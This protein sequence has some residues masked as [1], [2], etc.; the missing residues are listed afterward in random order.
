MAEFDLKHELAKLLEPFPPDAVEW[1]AQ[2][3]T[4][5]A[6]H[7]A[8]ALSYIDARC[9]MQRLDEV[10]GP[11]NWQCRYQFSPDGKKTI[12]EIGVKLD[13]EWVW[14]ADGAGDTDVEAE[15]GALSDSFKRAAVKWGV[16]RYLYD[17]PAAWVPCE[18]YMDNQGRP[19]FKKWLT[20]PSL[21]AQ[22]RQGPPPQ[23]STRPNGQAENP[24]L[25]DGDAGAI[26]KSE[27]SADVNPY[28]CAHCNCD[29][30]RARQEWCRTH[31][32]GKMICSKCAARAVTR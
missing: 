28:V 25:F 9:A 13:G 3:V 27:A 7:R 16:G 31:N 2:S 15:K 11:E 19:R 5:E 22:N 17:I 8:Q 32:A 6:P 21:H 14:K 30:P 26:P 4:R 18:V 23:R 20:D 24:D 12:C 1:R 10:V 29:L